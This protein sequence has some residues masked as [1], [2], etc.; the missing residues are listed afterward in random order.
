MT[1]W[2]ILLVSLLVLLA[3]LGADRLRPGL[4]LFRSLLMLVTVYAFWSLFLTTSFSRFIFVTFNFL[5]GP[6]F[7]SM[8]LSSVEFVCD[9]GMFIATVLA[10]LWLLA[11]AL[12]V[13]KQ[14]VDKLIHTLGVEV[15]NPPDLSLAA[16]RADAATL[17]WVSPNSGRPVQRIEIE[18]NGVIVGETSSQETAITV[19]GLKPSSYY[20]LR[21]IAVGANNFRAGSRVIKIETHKADGRPNIDTRLVPNYYFDDKKPRVRNA[22]G[23]RDTS[24]ARVP[25]VETANLAD[26]GLGSTGVQGPSARRNTSGRKHS[27]STASMEPPTPI[28]EVRGEHQGKETVA[29][30]TARLGQARREIEKV[31]AEIVKEDEDNRTAVE[32]I[33]KQKEELQRVLKE[34]S[35]TSRKLK[36][37]M[38]RGESAAQEAHKQMTSLKRLVEK[39][40]QDGI[41]I[42]EKMKNMDEAME[43]MAR[44]Q[45]I[46]ASERDM[47]QKQHDERGRELRERNETA[48]AEVAAL[49][50]ELKEKR[51]R[52]KKIE[53]EN[54]ELPSS[55]NEQAFKAQIINM[56]HETQLK[57]NALSNTLQALNRQSK[58]MERMIATFQASPQPDMNPQ[59]QPVGPVMDFEPASQGGGEIKR[60]SRTTTCLSAVPMASPVTR[61][62]SSETAT[63]AATTT[64]SGFSSMRTTAPPPGLAQLPKR[65][66]VGRDE[67][68]YDEEGSQSGPLSPGAEAS[69][70]PQGLFQDEDQSGDVD[71]IRHPHG[72]FVK[73]PPVTSAV[74]SQSPSSN[75]SLGHIPSSQDSANKL[76]FVSDVKDRASQLGMQSLVNAPSQ[77]RD[78]TTTGFSSLFSGFQR[79][80]GGKCLD[81][82]GPPLGTLKPGQSQSFPS[83]T[84]DS[85]PG[86]RRRASLMSWNPFNRNSA[87][88]GAL[89]HSISPPFNVRR[90][91]LRQ[92]DANPTRPR[93][94][95]IATSDIPRP[96]TDSGQML[97]GM[98]PPFGDWGVQQHSRVWGMPRQQ[99]RRTSVQA[100]MT[101]LAS[102]NDPIL[103]REEMAKSTPSQVG[104]IGSRPRPQS[105]RLNPA[106]PS[107]LAPLLS[108]NKGSM[109]DSANDSDGNSKTKAKNKEK[110]KE[111][112][113]G[114]MRIK[115]KNK[116]K[117]AMLVTLDFNEFPTGLDQSVVDARKASTDGRTW[118]SESHESLSLDVPYSNTPSESS[119]VSPPA[120]VRDSGSGLKKL[121]RKSSVSKFS[122]SSVGRLKK[123]SSSVATTA[124][125]RAERS[126]IS[127][128][129]ADDCGEEVSAVLSR[130]T[131]S[132]ASSPSL[133]VSAGKGR[134]SG[135][136]RKKG[137][138]KESVE[139]EVGDGASHEM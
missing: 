72:R 78:S 49:E 94:A 110:V 105:R 5:R 111:K 115:E 86:V 34:R 81:E 52:I 20:K 46:F 70:L 4:G 48:K 138:E 126:S 135:I 64:M 45:G 10:T 58:D 17:I 56:K 85:V 123:G 61:A 73:L 98:S 9:N 40:K 57:V 80:R 76:G 62:I 90:M 28:Q 6:S 95:S 12:Y 102:E 125:E 35:E 137:K 99:S 118:V 16:I 27:P 1:L 69:F 108:R 8:V 101:S 11:R 91:S 59:G 63:F 77:V 113:D 131:E 84:D 42:V 30:L 2:H 87:G 7:R 133:G 13:L 88:P 93:P 106:A 33:Q 71:S 75:L 23:A 136:L 15:P 121:F 19:S 54:K 127:V 68:D 116:E 109:E 139:M 21:V 104:V 3:V 24:E 22:E 53:A 79:N 18:V 32:D 50:K 36:A 100:L 60:T 114:K 128:S 83:Q 14:P 25:S 129:E 112:K 65:A 120:T 82:G 92:P 51:E 66:L 43:N 39:E 55:K 107:F 96:S 47:L 124:S 26:A 132:V 134:W 130:A 117:E 29:E 97:A 38:V 44:E 122:L 74:V 89:E 67:E 37:E 103:D 41:K 31:S 119:A